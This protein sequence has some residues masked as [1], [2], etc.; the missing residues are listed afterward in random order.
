V[1]NDTVHILLTDYGH[2][3]W[4]VT[5]PQLPELTG[6]RQTYDELQADLDEILAFGGASEDQPRTLHIQKHHVLASGDEI[7][8]R[9]AV[10]TKADAR[11]FA[12]KQLIAA[13]NRPAQ[14]QHMLAIPR[15]PTGEAL[16]ICAEPSDTIGWISEQFDEGDA[17]SVVVSASTEMIRA[18]PFAHRPSAGAENPP[19]TSLAEFGWTAQTTL[20]EIIR[21]QDS[22]Q[23]AA[24]TL[25]A[26]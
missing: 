10:D 13:L 22:G 7:L 14:T 11:W 16:F 21:Q 24:D 2:Y 20:S 6:G 26:I 1:A 25:V 15:R 18:Q 8:I 12:A 3:G 19:Q 23:L 5:S 9:V 17:A 4:G